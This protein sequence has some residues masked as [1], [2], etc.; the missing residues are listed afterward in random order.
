MEKATKKVV[1]KIAEAAP[2][3]RTIT[4]PLFKETQNCLRFG[5]EKFDSTKPI[6][7]LYVSKSVFGEGVVPEELVIKLEW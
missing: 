3:G 7:Q 2:K 4:L 1:K 5:E 6:S